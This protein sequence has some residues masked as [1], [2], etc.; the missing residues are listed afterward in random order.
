M[1]KER[2]S[3]RNLYLGLSMAHPFSTSWLR[4][5][6]RIL[7]KLNLYQLL[8]VPMHLVKLYLLFMYRK[9]KRTP[10]LTFLDAS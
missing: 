8:Q 6:L 3:S 10:F 7:V 5:L 4:V 2:V 1:Y 9:K